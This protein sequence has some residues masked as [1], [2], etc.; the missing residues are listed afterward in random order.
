MIAPREDKNREVPHAAIEALGRIVDPRPVQPMMEVQESSWLARFAVVQGLANLKSVEGLAEVLTRE[1]ENIQQRNPFFSSQKDPMVEVEYE[2][3]MEIGA[4]AFER[5]GDIEG[6]LELPESTGWEEEEWES[7]DDE[8]RASIS[9]GAPTPETDEEAGEN[10]GDGLEEEEPDEELVSYVDETAQMAV[11]A[12]QRLALP[13]LPTLD[14]ALLLRLASVPDLYGL[15]LTYEE[16][17]TEAE[18]EPVVVVDLSALRA[19]AQAELERR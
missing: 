8:P 12:L 1:M 3:L 5:T 4:R 6:L 10:E 18:P 7:M 14:E 16:S 11:T 17:E 9:W 19:A 13:T 2:A 15:D